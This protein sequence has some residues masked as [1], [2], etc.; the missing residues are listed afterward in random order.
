MSRPIGEYGDWDVSVLDAGNEIGRMS[1]TA[2]VVFGADDDSNIAAQTTL[3]NTFLAAT[4]AI[5]LGSLQK[6]VYV[7]TQVYNN[8]VPTNGA[9]RELKLLAMYRCTA[10]GKRYSLTV[11]TLNPALPQYVQNVS[12]RD[13]V[14]TSAPS[15][16]T[17]WITAFNAFVVA[18]DIPFSGGV[19]A[20]NPACTIIGL[21]VVGRNN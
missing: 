16:I 9:T 3:F 12:V 13:A 21:R 4:A 20:T 5:R 15:Q 2:R 14:L 10:T 1:G 18:P 6:T 19:Y 11:P 8:A 17:D 7:S